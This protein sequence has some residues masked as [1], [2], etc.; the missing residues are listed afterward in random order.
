M[1]VREDDDVALKILHTADWHLGIRFPA[2]DD[3]DQ[4]TL[5]RARLDAVERLLGIAEQYQVDAVLCAGDLFD[6]PHPEKEWWS[7]LAR[8]FNK[9]SWT[10]RPVYLLP[11]NHDPLRPDSV[12][13]ST[14]AFRGEL[15]SW[16]HVI[17]ED[18]QEIELV[19][20]E[21]VLYATPCRS[22]AGEEDLA[23]R[24]PSREDS[25]KRIRIGMVHGQTFDMPGHQSSFPIDTNAVVANG[26]D[27][28]ALGDTHGFRQLSDD[29][30][31]PVVY[32]GAPE[33]TKFGEQ[34][35]GFAAVVYFRRSGKK[36]SIEQTPVG[37]WNWRDK[38]VTSLA[39]LR[40][41]RDERDLQ[42]CVM[43]LTLDFEVSLKECDEVDGI[44]NDLKG[45]NA[46]HGR[47]GVMQ[48]DRSHLVQ[49]V[50]T[51]SEF[52]DEMPD[53]LKT[54]VQRLQ[55]NTENPEVAKRAML[56]LYQL[57][58]SGRSSA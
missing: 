52:D 11:G 14:H 22:K 24:L 21:A 46:A 5:S 27:Y 40:Q 4:L 29:P 17:E 38:K 47:V 31:R 33:P 3:R 12:Y 39:E 51:A 25:D 48:V 26:L 6:D 30:R 1:S 54:V 15:P 18:N 10:D 28:L 37:K 8:V 55:E 23:A 19:P 20:G 58:K 42:K 50:P 56:H 32:P 44:L 41:L 13:S 9:R 36:P 2:F 43:R 34:G 53:I 16:V 57:W 35:A 45:T 49:A 7:G